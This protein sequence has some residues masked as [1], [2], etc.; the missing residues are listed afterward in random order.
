[1]SNAINT[2][3]NT[4]LGSTG[5]SSAN[6]AKLEK[7]ITEY[8]ELSE[9]K[10]INTL[11]SEISKANRRLSKSQL[12]KLV[13]NSYDV[14]GKYGKKAADY[15]SS[16]QKASNAG[17]RDAEG[18]AELSIAAQSAG[19]MT[20]DLANQLII[21]TDKAYKMN[22]SVSELT[23]VLDGMSNISGSN[24]VNMTEL[25]EGMS[26]LSSTAASFGIDA[27]EAA[28]ALATM[29]SATKEGG[30]EAADAFR[31]ILLNIGQVADADSGITTEG[32]SRYE[33]ACRALNVSL[34]ETKNGVTSLRDPMEV[35]KE[36]SSG[37]NQLNETDMRRT[38]LLDSLGGELPA[39]ELDALLS[40]WDTYESMLQQYDSGAGLLA[41]TAE[42]TAGSW[43]GS[44]NRLSNTWN[45]TVGNI[46]NSDIIIGGMNVLN[47]FLGIVNKITDTL[48]PLGSIGLGAFAFLNKKNFNLDK[49]K[50]RFCP[51]WV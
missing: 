16:V 31:T 13:D 9:L 32:L 2:L 10:D 7:A 4:L 11:V 33:N 18:I 23:K 24:A 40:S 46:A 28:A 30:S 20:A 8:I 19:N 6:I 3:L 35:L 36:L 48:G 43:E 14:A 22:G 50:Q 15:L 34:K 1:M 44:M 51:S 17:Y 45:D 12:E 5:I 26:I 37:Y 39:I 41:T 27:N 47:G 49:S 21:A 25:S 42:K 38:N 29:I